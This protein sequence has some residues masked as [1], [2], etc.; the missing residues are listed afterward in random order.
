[1]Q[2]VENHSLASLNTFGVDVQAKWFAQVTSVTELQELLASPQWQN[3]PRLILGG[4]SNILF[5]KDYDGL[6]IHN[7]LRGEQLLDQDADHI[8]IRVGA[9]EN[10][11]ELVQF[12][13]DRGWGGIENLSLIPGYVGAA[14]IQNIGAYGV[15]L[16]DVLW[17]IE[18]VNI[19]TGRLVKLTA[20][21][22][23]FGYRDSIFKRKLKDQFV[24]VSVT[25]RLNLQHSINAS[26]PA[27]AAKLEE[28]GIEEP[29]IREVSK[30][31]IEI[32]QSKLPDPNKI[33]NA[34]S[35]FKNPVI[36]RTDFDRIKEKYPD[37]P[38]YALEDDTNKVPAAWLIEQCG[39]KGKK[40]GRVG[41]HEKQS[42]VLVNY[43]GANGQELAQHAM[44]VKKSVADQ[45]SIELQAE[46][47]IV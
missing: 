24:I 16:S 35:F 17:S 37:V 45:F 20:A 31:V 11:H 39:W 7:L 32:R 2:V 12:V 6:V 47:R 27:L 15:E 21:E 14:P 10:W 28:M 22:C 23:A 40:V 4:G 3:F 46:V 5:T 18:A 41:M 26:Y 13:I 19:E 9:G 29:T 43:G 42:L 34:G 36:S 44:D 8:W 1:M 33:G 30:A 38:S 25:L